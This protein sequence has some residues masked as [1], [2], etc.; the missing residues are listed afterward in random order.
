MQN[1][2]S[3]DGEDEEEEKGMW[4]AGNTRKEEELLRLRGRKEEAGE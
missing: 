2:S 4:F 3:K 1:E